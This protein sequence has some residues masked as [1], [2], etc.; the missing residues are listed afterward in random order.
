MQVEGEK[1][2]RGSDVKM[3]ISLEEEGKEETAKRKRESWTR[4]KTVNR[5]RKA[6]LYKRKK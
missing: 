2:E 4:T 3:K 1:T 5:N 6:T